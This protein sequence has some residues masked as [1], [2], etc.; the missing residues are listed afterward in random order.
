MTKA[1][2]FKAQWDIVYL[3]FQI[4]Y[5]KTQVE[6]SNHLYLLSTHS[7]LVSCPLISPSLPSSV[8][9][10]SLEQTFL[11]I[12]LV[13]LSLYRAFPSSSLLQVS[14][15]SSPG[16]WQM[17]HTKDTNSMST[18]RFLFVHVLVVDGVFGPGDAWF[19]RCRFQRQSQVGCRRF[20]GTFWLLAWSFGY[21]L[22][23]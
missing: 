18:I 3:S 17:Q 2:K 23:G 10:L 9:F 5:P 14:E 16:R 19:R 7:F 12:C 8:F 13:C 21:C 11:C 15:L 6:L 4:L 20:L 22:G 1:T